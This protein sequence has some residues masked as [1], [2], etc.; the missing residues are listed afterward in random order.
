MDDPSPIDRAMPQCVS[1]RRTLPQQRGYR[2]STAIS[3]VMKWFLTVIVIGRKCC[4]DGR[5]SLTMTPVPRYEIPVRF[6]CREPK[7]D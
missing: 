4:A 1:T 2:F 3:A 6:L 7:P 5:F